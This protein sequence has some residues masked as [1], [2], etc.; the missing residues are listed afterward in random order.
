MNT[1]AL[2]A[3]LSDRIVVIDNYDSFV[4]NLARYFQQL[5]QQTCVVRNDSVDVDVLR[6]SRPRMIVISPGPGRPIDAGA[7]LEIVRRL[8]R[9]VPI[10]GVCLGHQVIAEALGGRVTHAAEP[11]HGRASLITH[12]GRGVFGDL[13]SP[14]RVGRYHSLRADADVLPDELVV[15]AR[16]EDGTVMGVAHQRHDVV[17]LQFHPESILTQHGYALLANFLR[18]SGVEVLPDAEELDRTNAPRTVASAELP[19]APVTF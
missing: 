17:G 8:H 6:R 10:L 3:D 5:G 2:P 11:V 4:F 13:P 18:Q 7:S 19:I 12:D 15:T 1:A 14:L 9:D 16:S